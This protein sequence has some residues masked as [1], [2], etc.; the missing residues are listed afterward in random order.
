MAAHPV[1]Y[2]TLAVPGSDIR[3][4][5]VRGAAITM[6]GQ[7]ASFAFTTVSTVALAR[8][9]TP[10]AFGVVAMVTPIIGFVGLVRDLGLS[11]ATIQQPQISA[12]QVSTL[13]W[14]NVLASICIFLVLFASGP[15]IAFFYGDGRLVH[16]TWVLGIPILLSGLAVQHQALL[17]R[18]MQFRR[19]ATIAIIAQA[20]S[21]A[22]GILLAW[23]GFGYWALVYMPV[24]SAGVTLIA[25]WQACRWRPGRP[26]R[27]T[28][29]RSMLK[30]GGYLSAF[31]LCNFFARNLDNILIG[32]AW[33]ATELGL[34]SRAYSLLVLP[35]QQ[36]N[37]PM[38][39]VVVPSLSRLQDDKRRFVSFY[40]QA[41]SLS[42][43]I[44]LPIVGVMIIASQD[45]VMVLL[46]PKWLPAAGIF[47]ALAIS[48]PIQAIFNS[49]GWLYL[50]TGRTKAMFY[51][52]LVSSSI[53]VAS[54][55]IG[56]PWG[57][58]GVAI[59]YSVAVWLL[60]VPGLHFAAATL[61][62]SLR[63]YWR[64]LKQPVLATAFGML[65]TFVV[66]NAFMVNFNPLLRLSLCSA[67]LMTVFISILLATQ[68]QRRKYFEIIQSLRS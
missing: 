39:S 68:A 51:F 42:S 6:A 54:F 62:I 8:L 40:L 46:G 5:S 37:Q 47:L 48:A 27:H 17:A 2:F 58:L 66:R 44:T 60:F 57:P 19:L 65:V 18:N 56:L 63:D 52:V 16:V 26:L 1:D 49:V 21:V 35:I 4:K 67:V 32:R 10:E 50:P 33:G 53:T 7:G 22:T 38:A 23:A 36:I 24:L 30:M 13:F 15:G 41:L 20:V 43:S 55:V 3:G 29:V 25:T 34:Y 28:G 61:P 14:V 31:N 59:A 45:V 11:A 64:A 9:L 12:G